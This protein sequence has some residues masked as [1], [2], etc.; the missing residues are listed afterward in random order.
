MATMQDLRKPTFEALPIEERPHDPTGTAKGWT[1]KTLEH[2][3][4][5][6]PQAIEATDERG[7]SAI[8]VP[9]KR[10]GKVGKWT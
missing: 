10:R 1:F 5:T 4:H 2:D 3:E 7:R 6:F 8:Y 9:L